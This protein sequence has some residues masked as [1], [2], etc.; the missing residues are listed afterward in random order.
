M[1]ATEYTSMR[2]LCEFSLSP[3]TGRLAGRLGGAGCVLG[4][5]ACLAWGPAWA[6]PQATAQV[7]A[8][9]PSLRT[10]EAATLWPRLF[11]TPA[12]RIAMVRA[13]QAG[14][15]VSAPSDATASATAQAQAPLTT[16]VLQGMTQGSLGA[17][18]WINGLMLRNGDVLGGRTIHIEQQAVRL[19]QK[20]QPDVVL[21]P[22]Q[23]SLEPGQPVSDVVPVG[24]FIKK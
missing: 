13:R 14:E 21:R 4:M 16:F 9:V 1:V 10:G 7:A 5:A 8:A 23:S 22:G 12:Q 3:A 15:T 19:R 11:Y 6:S 24:T 2:T 17:S 20:G 18:A